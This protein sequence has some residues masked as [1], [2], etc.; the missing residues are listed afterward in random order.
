MNK[1]LKTPLYNSFYHAFLSANTR[2]DRYLLPFDKINWENVC[3]TVMSDHDRYR[4]VKQILANQ[5][6]D[7]NSDKAQKNLDDLANPESIILITGQQLGIFA[8]PIYTIYK[9]ITTIKL[10]EVLNQK[11]N[12][13][14]FIPVFWLETE[15]HDFQEI[16]SV[17]LMDRQ[18]DPRRINYTGEDRG[19]V[20]LRYYK[21]EG[22]IDNFLNALFSNLLETEFTTDLK[23]RLRGYYKINISWM[24]AAREF[25]KDMFSDTGLLFFEPGAED[26]KKISVEFFKQLLNENKKITDSFAKI[27]AELNKLGYPNQ[28]TNVPGKTFIHIEEKDHQRYHLYRSENGF[29]LKES[30]N[31]LSKAEVEQLIT[32]NPIR[33]STS[34]ISRPLLQSWLL[35]VAAYIAGPAEI[36][37]WAQMGKLFT[38]FDLTLP[39]VY[40]R[41]SA[42]LIEPKIDRY[43]DRYTVDIENIPLKSNLFLE[44]YFKHQVRDESND[45]IKFIRNALARGEEGLAVYLD[46]VDSTLIDPG[47]KTIER[48]KQT[49]DNFENRVIKVLEEKESRLTVHLEQIHSAFFPE[50]VPQERF[51]SIVYFLNKFGPQFIDQLTRKLEL[52]ISH[53]QFISL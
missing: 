9:L 10:A 37:Y 33:I 47:K 48:M 31:V 2:T 36:A 25:L 27:S 15:D 49:L 21:V 3:K 4:D 12:T 46:S 35:P 34:V 20:P 38:L 19:K 13:Y 43:I 11:N 29:R 53:H 44:T 42:T 50:G 52:D 51:L 6:N 28:V 8:S 30:D 5:N 22:Q 18:F 23:S 32:D 41:I 40:P 7:L 24:H 17:G 45:P 26:I 1:I 16:N 39:V 14:K